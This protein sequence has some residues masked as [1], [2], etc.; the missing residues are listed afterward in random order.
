MNFIYYLY[1]ENFLKTMKTRAF[2]LTFVAVLTLAIVN[3]TENIDESNR[4]VFKERTI[5]DY[6][7]Q[8][9]EFSEYVKLLY[10]V[11]ASEISQT[12]V[13]Q[14]LTA[15]GHYTV[16]APTNEAIQTY[17]GS[18]YDKKLISE[19]SWSGFPNDTKLDSIRKLIVYNS[20]I[21]SGDNGECYETINFPTTQNAEILQPNMYDWKPTVSYGQNSED[22][23]VNGSPLDRVCRDIP[24]INGVV[25]KVGA[26]VVSNT[27]TLGIFID[28]TV[29][30]KVEGFYVASLLAKAVG[31]KDT[32]SVYED[33][34][35]T[36]CY[37]EGKILDRR[38][39]AP[40]HRY[41]GFT[42]FAET[43]DFWSREIGKPA[44][45]IGVEDVVSYLEGRGVYPEATR[46]KNYKDKHNLLNQFVTYHL[47]PERHSADRLVIHRN[48]L[49]Y[50][51]QTRSLG[52]AL[53]EYYTTMGIPRLMK[54]YES[55]E[56]GG[57]YI[58]RFPVLD[59]ARHGNYH[60]LYCEPQKEGIRVG[61]P[62]SEA[63]GNLRN[64]MIY[65]LEQ[66]LVYDENTQTNLATERIRFDV[67][68]L[69]QEMSTNDIRLGNTISSYLPTD[70]EYRYL[71][72]A[73]L[74]DACKLNYSMLNSFTERG[75][76]TY[77]GD[78]ITSPGSVDITIQL[79]PVP[80]AGTYEI[81]YG[82][83]AAGD[84]RGLFQFFWGDDR[85]K[86]VPQGIPLDLRISGLYF[87][88]SK[89]M[90]PSGM[91]WEADGEDEERN[92]EVDKK[93]RNNG[94]MKGAKIYSQDNVKTGRDD[95]T[96]IRRIIVK[97]HMDPEKVY[98]LRFKACL[99]LPERYI[100]FDYLEYC[101]KEVYDNPNTPEDV[102]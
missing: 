67:A 66:L 98:Y 64:A 92:A 88:T 47:L 8:H 68:T 72:R 11:P 13:G 4:Y 69:F 45:E 7:K 84:N 78:E 57:V 80:R 56:S 31:L 59:N 38:G 51:S 91:A 71:E 54:F 95:E 61:T 26:V 44:L 74:N 18:L 101:S 60:E 90:R 102:W 9:E 89:E 75:Y 73:W 82:I 33:R 97:Q 3:C 29:E 5:M 37:N 20:V 21:D 58:N 94:F 1:P 28:R 15:R 14:L 30:E 70:E 100:V 49:G 10:E 76:C 43:D 22:I 2:L 40:R 85:D 99:D 96:Q 79:P 24:A 62:Y 41:I 17:L 50:D 39:T 23:Y 16:F 81:R 46:D 93:L 63:E 36:R 35:Y 65:P 53:M 77:M 52:C 86:L 48:E 27:N 34:E 55:K 12:T 32:L 6:L 83:S 25:H 87:R 42:Y 19:P